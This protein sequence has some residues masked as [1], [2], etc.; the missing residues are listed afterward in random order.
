MSE[1]TE[2][3]HSTLDPYEHDTVTVPLLQH[4]ADTIVQKIDYSGVWTVRNP[5]AGDIA[6]PSYVPI[7]TTDGCLLWF[8]NRGMDSIYVFGTVPGGTVAVRGVVDGLVIQPVGLSVA[9]SQ[10]L[11]W[12]ETPIPYVSKMGDNIIHLNGASHEQTSRYVTISPNIPDNMSMCRLVDAR[13][14]VKFESQTT[15]T[16]ALGG[17]LTAGS[18][19]DIRNVFQVEHNVGGSRTYQALSVEDIVDR[20]VSKKDL[21]VRSSASDGVT[22]IL[23]SDI[24]PELCYS[25]FD[26]VCSMYGVEQRF[27]GTGYMTGQSRT[28]GAAVDAEI[29]HSAWITPWN[30]ILK[31][32]PGSTYVSKCQQINFAG[33]M[34]PCGVLDV[35][36][37]FTPDITVSTPGA[38]NLWRF[39]AE[40][41]H[42]FAT[43]N[44]NGV[45]NYYCTECDATVTPLIDAYSNITDATLYT[46]N[47]PSPAT[48]SGK[49]MS[50][51]TTGM[52][53]GTQVV[54]WYEH[55]YGTAT[56]G[57]LRGIK[58]LSYLVRARNMLVPGEL[59]PCRVVKWE[60][61]SEGQTVCVSGVGHVQGIPRGM[62]SSVLAATTRTVRT[63][64]PLSMLSIIYRSDETEL[65]RVWTCKEYRAYTESHLN[66]SVSMLERWIKDS[67]RR[68]A[69]KRQRPVVTGNN[70]TGTVSNRWKQLDIQMTAMHKR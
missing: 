60:G 5:T 48:S 68:Q 45:I 16:V 20:S 18:F 22:C 51:P 54:L 66:I 7:K 47:I 8:P 10:T 52:Y 3:V 61:L 6:Y 44:E 11:T 65:K 37:S 41:V 2:Y 64:F 12:A 29:V 14:D 30:S 23:G 31:P 17:L 57:T 49:S 56:N 42:T 43:C 58:N 63:T 50:L 67:T 34:N 39:M 59:G 46:I 70:P 26:S 40:Y 4:T 69:K 55:L 36:I 15:G 24:S 19:D 62:V 38:T 27:A 25:D 21:V 33:G 28:M 32:G 9:G 13:L 35:T 1:N 53:I